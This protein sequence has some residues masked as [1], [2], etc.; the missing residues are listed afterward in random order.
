MTSPSAKVA[1][2][3]GPTDQQRALAKFADDCEA[4]GFKPSHYWRLMPQIDEARAAISRA[5]GQANGL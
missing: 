2:T 3:P 4:S 5:E 1:P